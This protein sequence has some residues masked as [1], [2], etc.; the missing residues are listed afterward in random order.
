MK[1]KLQLCSEC[2]EET[3][4]MIGKKQATTRSSAYTRR[5]TV[6][7][8]KCGKKEISNKI[9]GKR[10]IRRNNQVAKGRQDDGSN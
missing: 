5:S 1:K 2:K 3:W 4:H 8:T 6:E 10:I 7:C 9:T